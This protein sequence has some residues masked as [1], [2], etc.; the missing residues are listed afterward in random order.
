MAALRGAEQGVFKGFYQNECLSD[1]KFTARLVRQVM[2]AVRAAGDGPH[3]YGW[4]RRVLYP[5]ADRG[6]MLLTHWENHLTDAELYAALRR[7]KES[8]TC[9]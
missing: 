2:G 5:A 8:G 6:V 1:C 3:Y 7:Q 9:K 4:Q